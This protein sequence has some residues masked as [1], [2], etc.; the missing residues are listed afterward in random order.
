MNSSQSMTLRLASL[1]MQILGPSLDQMNQ[2][3]QRWV[4][5]TLILGSLL[6]NCDAC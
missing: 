4:P 3:F 1:E 5:K 6:R 2:K